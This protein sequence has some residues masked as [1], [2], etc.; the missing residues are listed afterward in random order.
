[1]EPSLHRHV[2]ERLRAEY[3]EM[4]GL[5]LTR[6]Q[7]ARLCGIDPTTCTLILEALLDEKFL[8]VKIDGRYARLIEGEIRRPRPAKAVLP[9]DIS[10]N[11]TT[12]LRR[13]PGYSR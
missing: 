6:P 1:M 10:T 11:D 12:P 7:V 5:R 13:L 8:C 9:W 3:L 2:L 4:P